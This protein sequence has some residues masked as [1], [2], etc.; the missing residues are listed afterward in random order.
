[1]RSFGP[2]GRGYGEQGD[3]A[4]MDDAKL[5]HL[6]MLAPAK[7]YYNWERAQWAAGALD[8]TLDCRDWANLRPQQRSLLIGALAPFFAGEDR[9]ANTFAPIM[10]SAAG[11]QEFAFMATQQVD[12]VRHAQFCSRFWREVFMAGSDHK[13]T[14]IEDAQIRCNNAFT[15]L[16]DRRL[17]D[18]VE[19]L[20]K[21]PADVE[22][23]IEAVTIYHLIVEGVLAVTAMHF[24]LDYCERNSILPAVREGLYHTKSDEHR[25]IAFGTWYLR[26]K[27]HEDDRYGFLVQST[28]ME[29]MPVAAAI[30][31]PGGTGACDGL[32]PVE[33]LD[34]PSAQVSHYALTALS[35]RLKVIGGATQEVQQFAASGAWRA[36]RLLE[37]QRG[38]GDSAPT[39]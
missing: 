30:V 31:V 20:R 27:C 7:L 1:M 3:P 5:T 17:K 28:L 19:R 24:V 29:L 10:M 33:F 16:F 9:V 8:F 14:A 15:Q 13:L 6:E 32:D 34:Y 36:A 38:T 26:Q 25:H 4:T 18:V 11:D 35:R 37:A 39:V 2:D 12:E 22:A 23:K 21:N